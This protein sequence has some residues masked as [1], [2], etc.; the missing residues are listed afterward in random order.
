MKN[1]SGIAN[2][3]LVILNNVILRN[4]LQAF[5]FRYFSKT[6]ELNKKA[7]VVTAAL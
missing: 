7:M 3:Y 1:Y 6:E 5:D 4:N 2:K